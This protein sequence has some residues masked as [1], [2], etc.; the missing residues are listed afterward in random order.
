MR[1]SFTLIELLIVVGLMSVIISLG[2]VGYNATT[3]RARDA[4]RRIDLQQIKSALEL[5]R[6]NNPDGVYPTT[7]EY[8]SGSSSVLVPRYL[9]SIFLDPKGDSYR[10]EA[11]PAG[12]NNS[13]NPCV[14]YELS[15]TLESTGVSYAVNPHSMN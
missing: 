7:N 2:A 9:P 6:S 10:Y 8:G 13:S 11:A 1:R 5:Y 12:C 4:R 3:K 15:T 14:S